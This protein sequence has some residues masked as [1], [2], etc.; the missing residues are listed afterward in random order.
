MEILLLFGKKTEFRIQLHLK[1]LLI[2]IKNRLF[3]QM[4]TFPY[5]LKNI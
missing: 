4:L 5:A 2:I 1:L 3:I